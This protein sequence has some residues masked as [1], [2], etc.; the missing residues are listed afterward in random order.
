MPCLGSL[1][2]VQCLAQYLVSAASATTVGATTWGGVYAMDETDLVDGTTIAYPSY[3][4]SLA[5]GE[6]LFPRGSPCVTAA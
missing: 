1:A 3:A 5:N 4:L 2:L 6:Q